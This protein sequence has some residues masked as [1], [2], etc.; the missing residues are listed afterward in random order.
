[1]SVRAIS[2]CIAEYRF[3]RSGELHGMVTNGILRLNDAVEAI[4]GQEV[5]IPMDNGTVLVL[6]GLL[7]NG[8]I[9]G[10]E[11]HSPFPSEAFGII[12]WQFQTD[13]RGGYIGEPI[14]GK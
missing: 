11:F 7:V 3:E 5:L 10:K 6:T 14:I 4:S 12:G 9:N 13:I 2:L 8:L 1:M